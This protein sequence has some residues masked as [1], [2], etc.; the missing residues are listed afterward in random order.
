MQHAH[1]E[2]VRPYAGASC[3]PELQPLRATRD[4]L[5]LLPMLETAGQAGQ[6]SSLQPSGQRELQQLR[7]ELGASC[8]ACLRTIHLGI[9]ALGQ[10]VA[11]CSLDL[12]DGSIHHES[13]ENLGF[14]MAE[15]GDLASECLRIAAACRGDGSAQGAR[16][17]LA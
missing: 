17:C 10:L 9:A 4:L 7:E 14:L 15:L 1:T 12:Q 6:V 13:V 8:E 5:R 11:R 2:Q 3:S 16:A